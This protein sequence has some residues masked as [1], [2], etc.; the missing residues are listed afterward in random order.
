MQLQA[1]TKWMS[2]EEA[3]QNKVA[4]HEEPVL[5]SSTVT[6]RVLHL[7]NAFDKLNKKKKPV[8]PPVVKADTNTTGE[9]SCCF[10]PCCTVTGS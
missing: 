7:K 1:F 2:E 6:A 5:E 4:A 8:P 9:F 10:T 3:K